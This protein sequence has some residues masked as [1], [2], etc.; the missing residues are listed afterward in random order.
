MPTVILEGFNSYPAKF[1]IVFTER[2][3]CQF[4][5][6]KGKCDDGNATEISWSKCESEG[7]FYQ[8]QRDD[9]RHKLKVN[10]SN[11]YKCH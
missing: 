11:L 9:L 8:V 7:F 1:D 4:E 2:D 10:T 3:K 5:W 6:F